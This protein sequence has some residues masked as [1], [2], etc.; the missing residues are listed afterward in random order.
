MPTVAAATIQTIWDCRWSRP[1][2]RLFDVPEHL[3]P[4]P[5]WVCVRQPGERRGVD[6]D[7]CQNCVNWE[8]DAGV[9]LL[10]EH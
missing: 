6:E 4:E 1:G 8:S 2:H 9:R 10:E 3:Q 5:L 7:A